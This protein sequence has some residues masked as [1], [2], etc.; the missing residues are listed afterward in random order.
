MSFISAFSMNAAPFSLFKRRTERVSETVF[1]LQK[2]YRRA[3]V[4]GLLTL[5]STALVVFVFWSAN[6]KENNNQLEKY[7]EDVL[8]R[9]TDFS[10]PPMAKV[11]SA[12]LG[13]PVSNVIIGMTLIGP[14]GGDGGSQSFVT[15][16]AGIAH[17]HI[18]L[19]PG[20]YQYH[21]TPDPK[22][23]F[24][25]TGW[26]PGQPYIVISGD[27]TTSLPLLRLDVASNR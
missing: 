12:D 1:G 23:R 11:I 6:D 25:W 17:Q 20:R 26:T 22:T 14:D 10:G 18:R 15:D 21:L 7:Y 8:R 9:E 19:A 2:K 13:A 3:I 27:E 5:S 24:T 16:E 4:A